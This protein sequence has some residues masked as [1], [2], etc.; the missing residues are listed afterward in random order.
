M[1]VGSAGL[2]LEPEV[3]PKRRAALSRLWPTLRPYLGRCRRNLVT[4]SIASAVSG[5]AQS[6][7]LFLLVNAAITLASDDDMFRGKGSALG[8]L[9]LSVPEAVGA[10]LGLVVV[11]V[12]MDLLAASLVARMAS[13]AQTEAR[14]QLLRDFL[15]SS[16]DIQSKE[17]QG[18][19]QDLLTTHVDRVANGA[20]M[21][22]MGTVALC[23]FA[24]LMVA[25]L[26]V[27]PLGTVVILGGTACLFLLLRP[28]ASLTRS[29]ARHQTEVNAEFAVQVSEVVRLAQEIR[30]FGAVGSVRSKADDTAKEAE[31]SLV[32]TRFLIRAL[33]SLY[34]ATALALALAAL[35]GVHLAD[36]GEIAGLGAVVLFLIRG[37]SYSQQLQGVYQQSAEVVSYVN[38]LSHWQ[39]RYRQH[40]VV[41]GAEHLPRVE[42]IAFRHVSF[43]YGEDGN[44]LEAMDFG[45][46]TGEAIGIVGPSGAGKS[47]LVQLLLR[48]RLPTS[49]MYLLNGR[50]AKDYTLEAVASQIAFVPQDPQ[51]IRGTVGD[52]IRFFR[53]L[54]ADQIRRAARLAHLTEEIEA[55]NEGYDRVVGDGAHGLS[56]GQRQ[57]LVLAR[58]LA[59]DP[60]VLIL[61]EPTSALDA[62]SDYLV[63]QSLTEVKDRLALFIVAH[64]LSTLECC[65]RIMVIE[66]GRL[67]AFGTPVTVS[68]SSRFYRQALRLSQLP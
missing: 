57:R 66:G 55:W 58:A 42:T 32:R 52:N 19:L 1:A 26:V 4:L 20:A 53:D 17:R 35:V 51:L 38:D 30:V 24:A 5:F 65:D 10:A 62:R 15:A 27:Q 41:S 31:R 3:D 37:L 25:A 64:R 12:C 63:R 59:G 39:A 8:H 13:A 28:L 61:D 40:P 56:G 43:A 68:G 47:T 50:D 46:Q 7:V 11:M 16:W 29:S 45:V 44:V 54:D 14:T 49:G 6:A 34:Q 2:R 9:A 33:P 18:H 23:N 67:T 48:L 36:M 21:L 22:G 60:S